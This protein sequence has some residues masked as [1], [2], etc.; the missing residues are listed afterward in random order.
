[1][2]DLFFQALALF[3]KEAPHQVRRRRKED[4]EKEAPTST[5]YKGGEE[6]DTLKEN[7]KNFI[8]RQGSVNSG[9][10]ILSS[11]Y[12][13]ERREQWFVIKWGASFGPY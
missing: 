9:V 11:E 12:E 10:I 4:T 3:E 5:G 1:M 2:P 7:F 13:M 8:E 6:R